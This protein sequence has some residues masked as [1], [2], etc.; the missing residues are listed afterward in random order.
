MNT[1]Y[2]KRAFS[3]RFSNYLTN[4]IGINDSLYYV[5]RQNDSLREVVVS[6]L[7]AEK[8]E[9]VK[10]TEANPKVIE[11]NSKTENKIV[12]S[13]KYKRIFGYDETTKSFSK[14]ITVVAKDSSI[15]VLKIK[16][17]SKGKFRKAYDIVF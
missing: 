1:T 12:D 10:K 16:D 14:K 13:K 3:K 8:K 9:K 11:T 17:F 2:L 4:E 5:F 6:R 15:A 7:K